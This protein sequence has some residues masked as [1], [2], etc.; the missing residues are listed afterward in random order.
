M[1]RLDCLVSDAN[2]QE[3]LKELKYIH[4]LIIPQGEDAVFNKIYLDV[5]K[6]FN[7]E[8]PGFRASNTRYHDLEHTNM[9][10]LAATRLMHGCF[11]NG[12]VF[13]CDNLILGFAAALFHDTGLILAENE[14]YGSGAV[15]T[16]GH[17]ERSI[18]VMSRYLSQKK[19][20]PQTIADCA[21]LIRCTI[22]SLNPKNISFRNTEIEIL[23]KIVGSADLLGQMADRCYLEKLLLL[24]KE[25]EEAKLP[26]FDSELE[27]LQKTETFY[28]S[29]AQKRL[30]KDFSGIAASMR[31]HFKD[32]WGED[33]DLYSEAIDNNIRYLKGLISRCRDNYACY[34]KNLR[35]GG[36]VR[37]NYHDLID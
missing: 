1:T 26:G 37:A 27:L 2:P 29:V 32:R 19:F 15:Y 10:V 23:G 11:L 7:G 17:E 34:L 14:P 21:A 36:I 9:V 16:L 18:A 35:R 25:F 20:S 30:A 12:H 22:L 8:Y 31:L 6:L 33:R 13:S 3:V 28:E 5:V 4:S 24:Y